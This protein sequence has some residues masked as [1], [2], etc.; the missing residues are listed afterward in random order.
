[1][2]LRTGVARMGRGPPG[3]LGRTVARGD[4]PGATTRVG[5][6]PLEHACVSVSECVRV[7]MCECAPAPGGSSL[8]AL[9]GLSPAEDRVGHPFVP[10]PQCLRGHLAQRSGQTASGHPGE[11]LT[12]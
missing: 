8:R 7:S 1:M 4:G 2:E 5:A 12:S 6:S 3:G 11:L 9:P 10:H